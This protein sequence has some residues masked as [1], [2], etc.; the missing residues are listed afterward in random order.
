MHFAMVLDFPQR[1]K[2]LQAA[3]LEHVKPRALHTTEFSRKTTH[4][5][6]H[7]RVLSKWEDQWM[8][9]SQEVN[10]ALTSPK[11]LSAC[12]VKGPIVKP[13]F[14]P[15]K[16]IIIPGVIECSTTIRSTSVAIKTTKV[17]INFE[18]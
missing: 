2:K 11:G 9:D 5:I 10:S 15:T 4:L 14:T 3:S 7:C 18:N 1:V 16:A 12:Q 8:K 13:I 17:A 6:V